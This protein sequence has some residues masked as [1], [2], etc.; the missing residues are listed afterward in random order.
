MNQLPKPKVTS[1][2]KVTSPARVVIIVK[3]VTSPVINSVKEA[4]NPAISSGRVATSPVTSNV[5]S[6]LRQENRIP[7]PMAIT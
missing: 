6:N 1:N 2:K 7:I 4:I 3:V 5:I